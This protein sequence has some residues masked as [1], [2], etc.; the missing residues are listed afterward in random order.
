MSF[1]PFSVN[2]LWINFPRSSTI[3]LYDVYNK[4]TIEKYYLIYFNK[5]LYLDQ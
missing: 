2:Y 4:I 5:V 3:V 1:W